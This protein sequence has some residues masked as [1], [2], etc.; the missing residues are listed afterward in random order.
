M[1]HSGAMSFAPLLI[2]CALSAPAVLSTGGKK[3]LQFCA[4]DGKKLTPTDDFCQLL[5]NNKSPLNLILRY[6]C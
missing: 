1:V 2:R 5:L 4:T 6:W 3:S